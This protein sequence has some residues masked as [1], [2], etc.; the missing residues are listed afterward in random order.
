MMYYEAS[1]QSTT[2]PR[3]QRRRMVS[4]MARAGLGLLLG[5]G[6]MSLV[7]CSSGDDDRG[8]NV[9]SARLANMAF[10]FANGEVFGIDPSLGP[11]NLVF[12]AFNNN[13]G[14]FLGCRK[15]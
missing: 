12:G 6:L 1:T 3:K 5:I 10:T 14:P 4:Q 2:R 13:S 11:V 7:S 8:A 15:F 9:T